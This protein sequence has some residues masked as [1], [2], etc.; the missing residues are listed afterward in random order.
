M[1]RWHAHHAI[2]SHARLQWSSYL[3]FPNF[4]LFLIVARNSSTTITILFY[5]HCRIPAG[6]SIHSWYAAWCLLMALTHNFLAQ[7]GWSCCWWWLPWWCLWRTGALR[8]S[9]ADSS[10][11]QSTFPTTWPKPSTLCRRIHLYSNRHQEIN[12]YNVF[13]L[14]RLR[15]K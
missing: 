15:C 12:Y 3:R 1:Y 13:L 4:T 10:S 6:C 2:Y 11:S 14:S 9:T 7:L 8:L 5:K